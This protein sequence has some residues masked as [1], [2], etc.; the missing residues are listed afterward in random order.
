QE[1][2][3]AGPV[4]RQTGRS[5]PRPD[6]SLWQSAH[7]SSRGAPGSGSPRTRGVPEISPSTR[8]AAPAASSAGRRGPTQREPSVR[9]PFDE[10]SQDR[11][12][13]D[14]EDIA[15]DRREL[16]AGILQHLVQAVGL[17]R[18]LLNQ[19]PSIAGKV[20]QLADR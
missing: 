19:G 16:D 13:R 17:S 14:A 3:P 2:Y 7:P 18:S 12:A 5:P 15:G 8:G 1:S 6:R 9:R 10:G 4:R 20:A 11:A